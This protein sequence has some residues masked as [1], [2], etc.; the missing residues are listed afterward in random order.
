M[1]AKPP[2][3]SA[4]ALEGHPRHIARVELLLMLFVA[5]VPHLVFGLSGIS[6]PRSVETDVGVLSLVASLLAAL[7]P[8]AVAV[9]LLWREGVLPKAG[10]RR[11]G[12]W[13]LVGL[14][15]LG[16]VCCIG[17]VFV[18]ASIVTAIISATG[19]HPPTVR[20]SSVDLTAAY[21]LAAI[22]ISITAGVAEETVYRGYAITRMEQA[23]WPR[24]ALFVPLLVW[25]GEH[26]YEGIFAILIV[27][28]VGV[29]L[30]WLFWWKR[31]VWP[32]MVAHT[33]YDVLI[34]LIAA[35]L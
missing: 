2:P 17:A 33:L 5:A 34:F 13:P 18:A 15:G 29:P 3:R 12:F 11:L 10:F 20:D 8:A 24:A 35:S 9:Y 1:R 23:G 7:G 4:D 19:Y 27:G 14:S 22:A 30:V 21:V 16:L 31:T 6:R 32:L 28:S 25:A 26:L